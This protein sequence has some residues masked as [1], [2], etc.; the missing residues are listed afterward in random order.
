MKN[1]AEYQRG[2]QAGIR[3][4]N[5]DRQELEKLKLALDEQK[6]RIYMKS[7]ELVLK[8]CTNWTIGSKEINDAQ[9]YCK[10]AKIFADNSISKLN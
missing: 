8:H 6:E 10:L 3:R 4:S 1:A 5:K 9:G 7:L 2:Y